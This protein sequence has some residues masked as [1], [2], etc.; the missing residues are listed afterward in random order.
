[1]DSNIALCISRGKNSIM[2]GQWLVK[3]STSQHLTNSSGMGSIIA[4][5]I[6]ELS[7]DA[8]YHDWPADLELPL[9][10]IAS[11]QLV[12]GQ[13]CTRGVGLGLSF[14]LVCHVILRF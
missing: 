6:V 9:L 13:V 3:K 10:K 5:C 1:M 11:T 12:L 7:C 4:L 14:E 2:Y 8:N